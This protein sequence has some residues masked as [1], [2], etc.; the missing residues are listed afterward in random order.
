MRAFTPLDLVAFVTAIGCGLIAGVFFAFSTFVM[1]ARAS[2]PPSQGIAAMQAINVVVINPWFMTPFLG[3]AA[4]CLFM[5]IVSIRRWGD[6]RAPYW[7]A[8]GLLYICGTFLVTLLFHVP[9][10]NAL[11]V[12]TP[13]DPGAATLWMS[14]L[15]AWTAGNHVRMLAALAASASLTFGLSVRR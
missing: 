5:V 13:A 3:T 2:L 12:V 14:Y 6:A 15:S 11:A 10:N 7:L 9:R 4:T 1:N 8:G